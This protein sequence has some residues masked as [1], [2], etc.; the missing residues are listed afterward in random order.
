ML[1]TADVA[2]LELLPG[3]SG[4]YR[5]Y[6]WLA[7]LHIARLHGWQ[8]A[9]A[10][11][12]LARSQARLVLAGSQF[13]LSAPFPTLDEARAILSE[14]FPGWLAAGV[15][16]QY[17]AE[18]TA[19]QL[20]VITEKGVATAPGRMYDGEGYRRHTHVHLPLHTAKRLIW[21]ELM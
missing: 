21:R 20:L 5:T 12:R 16:V 10:E 9:G 14:H 1:V 3:L 18:T 15:Q 2:G 13:S 6:S 4:L 11:N 8:L 17:A 7:P 19:P